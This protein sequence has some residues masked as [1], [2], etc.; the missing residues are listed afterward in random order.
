[1]GRVSTT[2][3]TSMKRGVHLRHNQCKCPVAPERIGFS[4]LR[5][6]SLACVFICLS[7]HNGRKVGK[8]GRGHLPSPSGN[9]S[10]FQE[11]VLSRGPASSGSDAQHWLALGSRKMATILP[12]GLL[13]S[14]SRCLQGQPLGV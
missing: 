5:N 3:M 13:G 10:P 8:M 4:A 14:D 9:W 6:S 12:C 7:L 1:M 2:Q 11:T